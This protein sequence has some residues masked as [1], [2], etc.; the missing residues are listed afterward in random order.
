MKAHLIKLNTKF[1][2]SKK[3]PVYFLGVQLRETAKAVYLY[4]RGTTMVAKKG[5]CFNCGRELTHPVSV[6]LGI[7]P[8]CGKHYWD[9]DAVGGFTPENVAR[10]KKE[11]KEKIK[12]EGWF[13]KSLV[14]FVKETKVEIEPPEWTQQNKSKTTP[15]VKGRN[16]TL[17]NDVLHLTFPFDRDLINQVKTISGR[18]WNQDTKVW[19]CPMSYDAVEK[20]IELKFEIPPEVRTILDNS[21]VDIQTLSNDI[22]VPGLKGTLYPFQAQGLAFLEAKNGR[23][24]IADE[25]GLG[26]TVQAIAWLQNNPDKRP[27]IL[28]VPASL[29]LNWA[30]ECETWMTGAKVHV[31]NGTKGTLPCD[32]DIIIINYDI[33]GRWL[34]EIL[35]FKPQ[36]L[37]LD[38]GHY[39][40]NSKA[41]RTKAVQKLGK[42]TPHTIVLTGTL[43]VNRPVEAYNAI[44][45]VD[46]NLIPNRWAFLHRYCGAK[47]NGFG[48]DFSGASN[49][50]ELHQILTSTI[51]LRRKKA[52]VLKDL[53]S[54]TRA[55]VPM[56]LKNRAK[57]F[58][59][60]QNFEQFL[61]DGVRS[62]LE[63]NLRD[64]LG[65]MA[66]MIA[67]DEKKLKAAQDAKASTANVLTQ[68][69][70]LKQVAVEGKLDKAIDWIANFIENGD[71]LVVMAVHKFVIDAVMKAFPGIAVKVD[72]SVSTKDRD[73]AVQ[74]FQNDKKT[75]IFVG[76]I[77]AAGVGLTLTASST[78]AFLELPWTPGD[79]QQAEDRVHRI[80]Q[81]ESVN[82]HYLLAA[83][84]IEEEIA[85]LLDDKQK[86]L[87]GVLDGVETESSS[88][89]KELMNKYGGGK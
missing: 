79:L 74:S 61:R 66:D 59:A 48:W 27:A 2:Q 73:K 22:D 40:K 3:Y 49:I 65:D 86:V 70:A 19:T 77:K 26:K 42:T 88:L 71:K 68:I 8:E 82:I 5:M 56:E 34:D 60:E 89:L 20:L 7:G 32:P 62:D 11:I 21:K 6:E 84:T 10:V 80:G 30:R 44:K 67:I 51:M 78:V 24:I 64:K 55:H 12:V 18:K 41:K 85:A 63:D 1:A 16:V 38:E 29:K 75:K 57:Y 23:G 28:I 4:G 36:T 39:I 46:K 47:N 72:G 58:K 35:K 69:E 87:D 50:E 53:P 83:G 15:Q 17:K 43:I 14:K 33:V 76:N 52:D 25:M 45:L 37:I 54:K 13:P 31:V 9:W 81:E